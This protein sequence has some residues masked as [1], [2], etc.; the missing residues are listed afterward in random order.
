MR[1]RKCLLLLVALLVLP[2]LACGVPPLILEPTPDPPA[3]VPPAGKLVATPTPFADADL[4]AVDALDALLINLY[5]RGNPAVVYIEVLG[6]HR[7]SLERLGSGSGFVIDGLGHIVT[8]DHVIRAAD[9]LQVTFA[10]GSVTGA[11]EVIGRDAYSDLAVIK[12][13]GT[14]NWVR[15]LSLG[16]SGALQVG[17]RVIAIGNLFGLQGTMTVG[18]VSAVGRALTSQAMAGC[19][20]SNPEIIQ[21]DASINPG[22]SGGPLA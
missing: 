9:A 1:R 11:V 16:D 20:F 14:P 3:W 12:V 19:S 22:N 10:D 21:T 2:T 17:Q 8:N 15:P 4:A 5:E 13:N 6:E 18:V 7:D